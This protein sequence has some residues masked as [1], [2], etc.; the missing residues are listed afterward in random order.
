MVTET[1]S[2]A[3][4]EDVEQSAHELLRAAQLLRPLW[5]PPK[6][7][8]RLARLVADGHRRGKLRLRTR[9]RRLQHGSQVRAPRHRAQGHRGL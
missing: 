3:I 7:Y 6:L 5:P 4:P 2:P 8:G 9:V 1:L